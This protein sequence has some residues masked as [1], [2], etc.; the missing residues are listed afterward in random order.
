MNQNFAKRFLT[1]LLCCM[2]VLGILFFVGCKPTVEP[3][4]PTGPGNSGTENGG[5]TGSGGNTGT[6]DNTGTGGNGSTGGNT[7][8]GGNSGTGGNEGTGGTT[9][10]PVENKLF[11]FDEE[12][13]PEYDTRTE[14]LDTIFNPDVLGELVLVFD[15]S[16]WNRHLEYCDYDL[17]HEES[18]HAKGFY[19]TKDNKEWFFNDIGFRIRGNTSRIRPQEKNADGTNGKYVQAHFALDF[20][21]WTDDDKKL[22]DSMKGIILKRAN[23][24]STYAREIYG[25]NLFRKNGIWIAPRAA[26]T[27]LKIQIIDDLDL[28]KDGDKTE[29]ETVNYGVYGMIEEIKKQFLKE[30][31]E[32]EGGGNLQSNKG[33]L[34]KCLWQINGADFVKSNAFSIGEEEVEFEFDEEGKI[35]K[36]NR[37]T[38]DYDYKGDNELEEGKTQLLDF[39]EELNNLPN[40]TDGNNDEAD[41]QTIKTFYTEK[42]DGD[43]FLRT[44]AINVILGM[45]DDY[46][47][48]KNNYYFYFDKGGKAYFIPYDYDN[49]LGTNGCETNAGTKNPLEWGSLTDGQ[50]PLIQKILQVP[51]YMEAYKKYLVD[52][53][54]E[55]SYFDDD[56]SI[57]QITKWHNMIKDHIAS[58][59]LA[60]YSKLEDKPAS[61][62]TPYIPYTIYTPGKNNFFTVRQKAIQACVNPSNEKLT[63]TLNAGD[64][65]FWSE[66]ND[67]IKTHSYEFS[68]GT[69]L[70][71]IFDSNDF[72][73]WTLFTDNDKYSIGGSLKY[74]YIKDGVYYYPWCF[75]DSE[76]CKIDESNFN[77]ITLYEDTTLNTLY[78]KYVP[79]TFDGN[80]IMNES[81]VMYLLE[82]SDL[83]SMDLPETDEY[84][85]IGWTL[86]PG[87]NEFVTK[88]PSEERILYAKWMLKD[89]LLPF[90][91][92]EDLSKV[93]FTFRP[94]DYNN[95]NGC[96]TDIQSVHLMAEFTDGGWECH[97]VNKLT[98]DTDGNYSI[99]LNTNDIYDKWPTFKFMVNEKDW[100]GAGELKYNLPN[101]YSSGEYYDFNLVLPEPTISF[102]LNGGS[103]TSYLEDSYGNYDGWELW[104]L[105]QHELKLENPTKDGF[106]F[107]GWTLTKDGDDFVDR[108]PFG[109]ITVYAKWAEIREH[110][111]TLISDENSWFV[112]YEEEYGKTDG[113]P[114]GELKIPFTTGQTLNDIGNC[115]GLCI[116]SSEDGYYNYSFCDEAGNEIYWHSP[117]MED[118]TVYVKTTFIPYVYISLTLNAD[119]GTF[120][121]GSDTLVYQM[122]EGHWINCEQ[123]SKDG[124]I[125]TGWYNEKGERIEYA[126]SQYTSL[127]AQYLDVFT[128]ADIIGN[129]TYNN[130]ESLTK[131]DDNTYSY[132]FTYSTDMTGIWETRDGQVAFKLRPNSALDETAFGC[133]QL[134]YFD[135]YRNCDSKFDYN[136][137]VYGLEN[138]TSYTITFKTESNSVQVKIAQT[139][140]E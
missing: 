135:D 91:I 118:T 2:T 87:G 94:N 41:I 56:K 20:E 67:R 98:K 71:E 7:G 6:G 106:A 95:Y 57:A 74:S 34:L 81:G 21:E 12:M 92:S 63:L 75:I 15:R 90:K 76:G 139:E 1:V 109:K 127:Y 101:E 89:D 77:Q 17:K 27:T 9:H 68:A 105:Y 10:P 113:I 32:E 93:T 58:D 136:I 35:T 133:C 16:E 69:T 102:D 107:V 73:D 138:G 99:T 83:T 18:V 55:D 29:F 14:A 72:D 132:T 33:N 3:S 22:A 112:K 78:K 5:N 108:I 39:M 104:Y 65:Y 43:L 19:F 66:L 130:G 45:W 4:D 54:N 80:V 123:P 82:E 25:Y 28:D 85:C 126:S 46:W 38:Y 52:Y 131:I 42:M 60:Y 53:S 117:L 36:F 62:G 13:N 103:T 114:Y 86:T 64:G 11:L 84:L 137:D 128:N 134:T 97:D 59:D 70:A 23:N 37:T 61:W 125:F 116:E 79:I 88:V 115:F 26:Y 40:C 110:T 24:D 51:E 100:F 30:R 121:D 129:M 119:G 48:N 31:T 120:G 140:S 47:V 50:R 8:T 44:Y 124:H 96:L 122:P 111:L 49:I